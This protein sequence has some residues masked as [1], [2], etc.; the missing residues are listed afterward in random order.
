MSKGKQITESL[1]YLLDTWYDEGELSPFDYKNYSI[2][3]EGGTLKQKKSLW[4]DLTGSP[5][6]FE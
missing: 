5:F 3:A 6:E 4:Y 1:V 2:V